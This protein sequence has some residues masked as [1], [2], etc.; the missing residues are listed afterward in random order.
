MLTSIIIALAALV[1][2]AFPGGQ[3]AIDKYI[4]N[5]LRYPEMAK[6]IGIEGVVPLEFTIKTDGSVGT[7]KVVRMIDP[8]LEQEAIRLVKTMP[9]WTPASQDGTAVESVVTLQIPF[10]LT[11]AD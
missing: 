10:R 1:P 11:P 7:I 8:D 6:E 3:P 5:N 4:A 9:K 2:A